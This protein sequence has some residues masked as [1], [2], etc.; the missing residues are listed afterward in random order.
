[1]FEAHTKASPQLQR[2]MDGL[3][4]KLA[5]L[6]RHP[7]STRYLLITTDVRRAKRIQKTV[8]DRGDMDDREQMD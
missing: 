7:T 8:K 4:Q 5:T 1:M 2:T 6:Y 3:R